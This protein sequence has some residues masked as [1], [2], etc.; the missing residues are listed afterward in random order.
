MVLHNG[1]KLVMKIKTQRKKTGYRFFLSTTLDEKAQASFRDAYK[2]FDKFKRNFIFTPV[3]FLHF[4]YKF[5]GI[6][7]NED[8]ISAISKRVEDM[9]NSKNISSFTHP[10]DSLKFGKK[11]DINIPQALRAELKKDI[12]LK[13]FSKFLHTTLVEFIGDEI[14]RKKE[15]NSYVG[16]IKL[17]SVKGNISVEDYKSIMDIVKKHK[18]PES[19]VID[20][21]TIISTSVDRNRVIVTP[22]KR[23]SLS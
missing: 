13:G 4:N 22:I 21:L 5:L 17:A 19:I 11:N 12:S 6:D 9:V 18:L 10:L 3:D 2:N 1:V 8:V 7:L 14:A 15:S 16:V 23:I 20:N